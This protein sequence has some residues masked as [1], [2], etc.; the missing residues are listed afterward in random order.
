MANHAQAITLLFASYGQEQNKQRMKIY[1]QMLKDIPEEVLGKVVQKTIL[2]SE[3]LP[4]IAKLVEACRSLLATASGEREVPDWNE[5]WAEVEKAMRDTPWGGKPK[6]SHPAIEQAVKNYGWK[7]IHE[8][9]ADDYHTMQAQLRR[10]YD[11]VAKGFIENKR[12]NIILQSDAVLAQ[13]KTLAL[14]GER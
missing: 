3:F 7:S 9:M 8:V 13:G 10:V 14:I 5:A 6:F 11:E 1:M 12:N 4:S 2:E